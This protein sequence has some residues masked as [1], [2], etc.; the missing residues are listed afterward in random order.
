MSCNEAMKPL[1]SRSSS[2]SS[3]PTNKFTN[4]CIEASFSRWILQQFTLRSLEDGSPMP[5]NQP[6]LQEWILVGED[7]G[8]DDLE[9]NGFIASLQDIKIKWEG[10]E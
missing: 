4:Q 2:P 1:N 6:I 5:V 7:D 9:F 10:E 8:E 3:S